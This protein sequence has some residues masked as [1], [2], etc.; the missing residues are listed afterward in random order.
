M[1]GPRSG[2]QIEGDMPDCGAG[3][4][5]KILQTDAKKGTAILL[6][7]NPCVSDP[8]SFQLGL[9]KLWQ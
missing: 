4:N 6:Q 1:A 5:R 3:V 2:R 8:A 7:W 9:A